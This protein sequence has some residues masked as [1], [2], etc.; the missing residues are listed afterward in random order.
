MMNPYQKLAAKGHRVPI[1][2]HLIL[3]EEPDP[4]AV[5]L[6]GDRLGDVVARTAERFETPLAIPLMDLKI[7]K[8]ALLSAMGIPSDQIES[9]HFDEMPGRVDVVPPTPR[10][11]ATC[12]AISR[13]ATKPGLVPMGMCIGPFSL[14]TKLVSDPI[15]PVYLI[16]EGT[17]A[18]EDEDVATVERCLEMGLKLVLSYISD[19][20]RAGAKGIIVCEPAA[21]N[22]YFSP[23]QLANSFEVFDRFVI[24]GLQAIKARLDELGA[25]FVLHDCGE[26]TPEMVQRFG[27]LNPKMLSLGCSRTLWEDA[28]WVPRETVLYGNLP[29]KRFYARDLTVGEVD[30]SARELL[31]KMRA[32]EHPFILGSECD[33]LSVPGSEDEIMAKV[34]AMMRA[35]M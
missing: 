29:S 19:Q 12:G 32:C 16:G 10:M 25:D 13:V 21:N 33:I 3:H 23:N 26:L 20:V 22:V 31:E 14:M 34:N 35:G 28:Q 2:T 1:A 15:T 17:T 24:E 9:Y 18:A 27:A 6:N 30:A 11:Q 4:A 8:E 7:E 5:E